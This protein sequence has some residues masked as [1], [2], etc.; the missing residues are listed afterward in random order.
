[1]ISFNFGHWDAHNTK[2]EY[3]DNLESIIQHLRQTGARL[4]W[5]TTCPVPSGYEPADD[6]D[7]DGNAPGRK[8]G[9]MQKYINPWALEVLER[10]KDIMICDQWQFVKDHER[11]LYKEWWQGQNVHFSGKAADELGKFL[12]KHILKKLKEPRTETVQ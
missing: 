2:E 6:L 5:V 11:D 10:H 1:M 7:P 8:A 12:A 4:V 9:V 3:Q